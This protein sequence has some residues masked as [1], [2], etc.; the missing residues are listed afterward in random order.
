MSTKARCMKKLFLILN[1]SFIILNLSFSQGNLPPGTY[2]SSNK[3][4]IK[5]FEDGKK[6][7]EAR[8]DAEAEKLLLKAVIEDK[9][10]VEP[11]VALAY[12]Y[13]EQNK[14]KEG[15][16][17]FQQAVNLNA[18]YFPRCVFDL[19]VA[20]LM[21]GLY[22]DAGKNLESYLKFERI[23]PTTKEQAQFYLKTAKYGTEA[24]KKPKPFNPIN[25]GTGINSPDQE[26]FP[27]ITADGKTIIFTRNYRKDGVNGQEDF[28]VSKKTNKDWETATPIKEVNSNGNEGAPSISA[29]GQYMFYASC[30]N[31]YGNYGDET[32]KGFGSCD[33][34]FAQQNSG[35]WVKPVNI[36]PPVNT[37][38]WETQP[39]FSSDGKT[40]YF[41]RGMVVRGDIKEQDIYMSE[42]GEDGKFSMPVKL[43]P[44]IN[45]KGKE[46]SVYIHPDNQT[47]YF[48]SDGHP[49]NLGGLDLY[50]SRK[51]ADGSWGP[52]IN[53]GYPINSYAD[54]NSLLVDPS[55]KVAYFASDR[56]GGYG[57]LDL[58]GF[59]LPVDV[60][61]S[62]ITYIKG[63]VFDVKTKA[64]LDASVELIDLQ[65]QK[66]VL[67]SFSNTNGEFL[68]VLAVDKNYLVN[69]SRNGYLFYSDNFS[70]KN[71]K[72]DFDRPFAL[73]I[74]LQ[75]IDTGISIEL[76]NIFFDVDKFDLKPESKAECEKLIT[77]LKTNPKLR[78]EISGHTDSDGN[79][80]ANQI[81]SQNRAKAVH[82]YVVTA[83]IVAT[84]L[85]FKGYGDSKPKLPNTSAE[86]KAKNRRTE[87]KIIGK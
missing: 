17:H 61:P 49:E 46:E 45:T 74:P 30:V 77:F 48:S 11:H 44:T 13:M 69:V 28:F 66:T 82:D 43:G 53:L 60:R 75:P 21:C 41:I 70:L 18:K 52:A 22:E 8:K 6:C 14:K 19:G 33:I 86:N 38:N 9:V 87:I 57:G 71:T 3:K 31:M 64:P 84:R 73:E 39:S 27:S 23:N 68:T 76:K 16:Y 81:L 40:L 63:K 65:T 4:A 83:G 7:Y 5:H 79:K 10:F 50:M 37:A 1:F 56:D 54:D 72:A 67:K 29:D 42:I 51:Q 62:P 26:Y 15:I 34:F 20:Q 47:L 12:L 55:G 59:E 32:R 58:Y 2:T 35:K 24:I 25:L 80:K 78:I 36:G 85:T